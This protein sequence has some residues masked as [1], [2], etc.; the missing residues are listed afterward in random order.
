MS[1]GYYH[2]Q[3]RSD[4]D[5][6]VKIHWENIIPSMRYNFN[7][8][9]HCNN[10]GLAYDLNSVMHYPD[11]AFSIG[12][13]KKTITC[14]TASPC[15]IGN[16][17]GFSANDLKGINKLYSCG[18]GVGTCE[19]RFQNCKY[20]KTRYCKGRYENWMNQHCKK[21]CGKCWWIK[22]VEM[23]RQSLVWWTVTLFIRNTMAIVNR[24]FITIL[25]I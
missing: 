6:H 23:Y 13:G 25:H 10:Q 20:W 1:P 7:K 14:K 12:G 18:G 9:N 16:R 8:C 19:D 24:Y 21:S 4:R 11:W 17:A 3:S 2:E 15:K 5:D 22:K